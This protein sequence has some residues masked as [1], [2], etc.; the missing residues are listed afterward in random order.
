M[1]NILLVAKREFLN[2]VKN[3]TFLIMTILAPLLIVLF[4]GIVGFMIKANN[5]QKSIAI[6]DES[7]LFSNEFKSTPDEIYF[8]YP[9][10]EFQK[11][12]DSLSE[13]ESLN[14]LL[15]IP[16]VED[17]THFSSLEKNI[18]LYTNGN[19]NSTY[20]TEL[21]FKIAEKIKSLKLAKQGITKEKLDDAKTSVSISTFNV[22]EGKEDKGTF[23]KTAMAGILMY[24]VFMFI[25][26]Y[27]VRVMRSVIEEK[28]NR[29]VE[30]IISSVKPF[31]LMMGKILGTTFVALTQFGI[32][33]TMTLILTFSFPFLMKSRIQTQQVD[34]AI[35]ENP[36]MMEKINNSVQTV[37]SF[38]YPLIIIVF[39]LFFLLG[40]ILY[41]A[42]FAAIGS[43]VDNDT[44]TQQFTFIA[45]LP[46]SLG[47][48]GGFSIINNPDGPVGFWLSMIPF[49]SPIAMIA[50]IP[51]GVPFWQIIL[52]LFILIVSIIGMTFM[53]SK[54]YRT[55]IL[56]YGKKASFKELWKWI[57]M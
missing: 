23:L 56:M 40:Y 51:F 39:L 49:T 35:A 42:M 33:I 43:A 32:W 14:A 36:D 31:H 29:V 20:S 16:K 19:L 12:K 55:G 2:Q 4:G 13:S 53:A 21:E 3:K 17:S 7:A 22:K 30:I 38:D 28:N 6:I 15:V 11:I 48:Y 9:V 45:I 18:K 1:K 37:L 50:R 34:K 24:V 25:M 57:R 26:I 10:Q 46:L 5:N 8:H 41:S 47:L 52:S 54:I 44:D 27:G